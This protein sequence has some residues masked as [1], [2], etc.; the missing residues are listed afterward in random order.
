MSSTPIT[1]RRPGSCLQLS[2]FYPPILGGI[3]TIVR[4]ITQGLVDRGWNVD[5]LCANT[6]PTTVIEEGHPRIV[7]AASLAKVA[8]TSMAPAMIRQLARL[9]RHDIVHIHLPDPM[10]NLA[11][12]LVRP[13]ARVVVHWH[14]D[15]VKQKTLLKLYAPL[16]SWLLRR[17]DAIIATSPP[18]AASSPWL[19]PHMDKV[20]FVPGC[21]EDPLHGQ[22]E[23]TLRAQVERIRASVGGR[24]IVFALGRM[25]Y[26]KGFDVLIDAAARLPEDT[27]VLLGGVGELQ[28]E[29]QARAQSLGLGDRVRFVGRIPEEELAAHY[30]AADVFCLPSLMRSEAFGMVLVEALAHGR[31]IVA[32]EIPGSGVPWVNRHGL[33]GLN[34]PPGDA[35]ALA[36]ALNRLLA[37]SALAR[38]FGAAGR[39]RFERDF[40]V[41]TMIDAVEKLYAELGAAVQPKQNMKDKQK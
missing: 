17:A 18:Y 9:G 41:P 35:P 38:T 28:E 34:V 21:I 13:Q 33:S 12:W 15:I 5:V 3:E 20:H 24:R 8:S 40:T 36:R 25:T 11:L 14:S 31:P 4:D 39:E 10:T 16:Q 6:Q 22:D 7:R 26:Y 29:L 27:V 1:D 32:T 2:K 30:Q 23:P 19:Q 37:D